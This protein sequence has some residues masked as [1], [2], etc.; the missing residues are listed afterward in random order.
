MSET[1]QKYKRQKDLDLAKSHLQYL[2]ELDE[3]QKNRQQNIENK[4]SQL[5]GQASIIVSIIA[6]FVPLL[7]NEIDNINTALL[8]ILGSGFLFIIYNYSYSIIYAIETLQINKYPYQTRSTLTLTKENRSESEIEFINDEIE[9]LVSSIN[10]NTNQNNKKGTNLI[11]ATEK[12][13]IGTI[14]VAF[15]TLVV[16]IVG[17]TKEDNNSQKI[18][19]TNIDKKVVNSIDSAIVEQLKNQNLVKLLFETNSNLKDI[20]SELDSLNQLIKHKK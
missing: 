11:N 7:I 19:I 20:T 9:D 13:R 17:I 12:F 1:I 5:V 18:N 16:I 6:L 8:I 4:N 3:F 2:K 15:F 14:S 10:H